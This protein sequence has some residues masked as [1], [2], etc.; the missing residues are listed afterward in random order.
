M[1]TIKYGLFGVQFPPME[2]NAQAAQ[3][4]EKAGLDF[5][6]YSDQT[7][8]TIPRSIWTP[9]I[10]PAAEN[11]DVDTA[12]EPFVMMSQA[13]MVTE[14]I[15]LGL[16]AVDAYRRAPPVIAHAILS[17]DQLCK[18]R[19]H[20]LLAAG[21]IKQF[22]SYGIAR[23]KPFRQ[24]EE[25]LNIVTRLVEN[26]GP[27]NYQG[28]IWNLENALMTCPPY[29][30]KPP[31]IGCVGG[32][33]AMDFAGRLGRGW[34]VFLPPCGDP[35]TF[36]ADVRRVKQAAEQ[37]G[38]DPDELVIQAA[39]MTLI[40]NDEEH[41][42][43]ATENLALRWDCAA[44]LVSDTWSKAGLKNP[45]GSDWVY[46][47]DLVPAD[48]SR[49]DA[50]RIANAVSPDDVRKL[51]ICGTPGDAAKQMQPYIEAGANYV[52]AA[53]Y[54]GLVSTGQLA[55]GDTGVQAILETYNHLRVMNDQPQIPLPA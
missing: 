21:E 9:D 54:S 15:E 26:N 23:E 46:S 18:G 43:K 34:G 3:F 36:A 12:L 10:I 30:N 52:W 5:I 17:L 7:C 37:A 44:T 32:G 19:A 41:V 53:N 1:S 4:Y 50:L 29:N 14:K 25:C 33:K 11:V 31:K 28:R 6:A 45:L 35:E 8:F 49:E 47:R 16:M 38:K 55:E 27:V 20:F 13:A 24:I 22:K 51:R 39:F 48:W 40:E 42:Q 2:L